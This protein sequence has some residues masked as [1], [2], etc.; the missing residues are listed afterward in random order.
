MA[1]QENVQAAQQGYAAFGRGDIAGVLDI[2]TDDVEWTQPGPADLPATGTYHGKQEVGDFFRRLAETVGFTRFEPHR[3]IAQGDDVVALVHIAG[4]ATATGKSF[5]SEDAHL[6]TFRD[7][8]LA[9]FRT[10]T[11]TEAQAAAVRGA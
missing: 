7:G 11:D 2:C 4:T 5:T 1:E 8:K 9:Q 6:F 10:H 3:F